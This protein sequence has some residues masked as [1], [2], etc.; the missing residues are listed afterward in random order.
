MDLVFGL[1]IGGVLL[2]SLA[3]DLAF[4]GLIV[5]FFLLALAYVAGC[6]SLRKGAKE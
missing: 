2:F 5:G 1:L 4:V 6:D 3:L